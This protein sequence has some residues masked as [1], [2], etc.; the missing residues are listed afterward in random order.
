MEKKNSEIFP[1]LNTQAGKLGPRITVWWQ[2]PP[3]M[4]KV[5]QY[6][7]VLCPPPHK[8]T[9]RNFKAFLFFPTFLWIVFESLQISS[10]LT[11]SG[12]ASHSLLG[13]YMKEC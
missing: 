6:E 13:L 12:D 2:G 7:V 3:Q 8:S 4:N 5:K 11:Q 10:F 1:E 9:Q